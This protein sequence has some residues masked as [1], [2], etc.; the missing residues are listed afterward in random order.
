[1]SSHLEPAIGRCKKRIAADTTKG[2]QTIGTED[3]M[4]LLVLTAST[5]CIVATCVAMLFVVAMFRDINSFYDNA[6]SDMG[7]FQVW[8]FVE[9]SNSHYICSG[10]GE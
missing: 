7:E 4:K 9:S 5:V 8:I 2:K 1:M 6:L 10:A 3:N